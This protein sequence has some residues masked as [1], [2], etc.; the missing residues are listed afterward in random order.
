[1]A[2]DTDDLFP[3]GM[4]S[5]EN[6]KCERCQTSHARPRINLPLQSQ[7][8]DLSPLPEGLFLVFF[9]QK[10]F[11]QICLQELGF[12]MSLFLC[13][14]FAGYGIILVEVTLA[15]WSAILLKARTGCLALLFSSSLQG[16]G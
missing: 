3:I 8:G 12:S 6:L 4:T 5:F 2:E 16:I 11:Q 15:F 10:A 1:M 7:L 13:L 14:S 9:W